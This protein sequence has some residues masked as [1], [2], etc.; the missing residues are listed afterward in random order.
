M[1]VANMSYIE[2]GGDRNRV[3]VSNLTTILFAT[4]GNQTRPC[5][6]ESPRKMLAISV[7]GSY[8]TENMEERG[9]VKLFLVTEIYL[10]RS[11]VEMGD[12]QGQ[13]Q[14]KLQDGQE[15]Y[16]LHFNKS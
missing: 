14:T 4:G 3:G 13:A 12:I 9:L 11:S 15:N 1:A 8:T 5:P 16:I 2:M 6:M 7:S 10:C